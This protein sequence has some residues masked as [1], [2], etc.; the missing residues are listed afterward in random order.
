MDSKSVKLLECYRETLD[1]DSKQRYDDKLSII[2][3]LDPYTIERQ[4]WSRN[5]E[6]W[7]GVTY[8]DIVNFLLYTTSA[9]TLDDLKSYKGLDAYNQ[10]VCGWVRDVAVYEVN[11]V[12][13]HTCRVSSNALYCYRSLIKLKNC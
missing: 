10:F 1:S 2:G 11:D 6:K 5:T 8:P 7:A 4:K 9:Y 3:N 13:V 12:C